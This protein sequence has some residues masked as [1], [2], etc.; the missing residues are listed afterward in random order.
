MSTMTKTIDRRIAKLERRCPPKPDPDMLTVDA[1]IKTLS[2]DELRLLARCD[3]DLAGD[4]MAEAEQIV[5][6]IEALLTAR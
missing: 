4:E 6:K 1:A 5:A 2:I 3:Q